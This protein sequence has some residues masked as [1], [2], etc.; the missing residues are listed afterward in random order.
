MANLPLEERRTSVLFIPQ[1]YRDYWGMFDSDDRCTYVPL[2]AVSLSTIAMID[3]MPA[4][5]CR[6]T[7]QYNMASY[8]PRTRPQLAA[9]ITPDA[10]CR[11]A[12]SRGFTE[13][14][15]LAPDKK[16]TPRRSRIRC[17]S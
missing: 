14:L 12:R 10:L 16:G 6:I 5:G 7:N 13:V 17:G 1:T 8:T 11:K 9:D 2:V 4:V 3:G 15:V